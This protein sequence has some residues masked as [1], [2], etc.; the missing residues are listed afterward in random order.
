MDFRVTFFMLTVAIDVEVTKIDT[1]FL[2]HLFLSK[3]ILIY[4]SFFGYSFNI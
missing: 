1:S 3:D 2:Y 4:N